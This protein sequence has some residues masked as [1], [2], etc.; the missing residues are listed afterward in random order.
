MDV[1]AANQTAG[2]NALNNAIQSNFAQLNYNLASQECDTRRTVTDGVRD[3]ID[4]GANNTRAILDFLVQDKIDT[5]TAEN[6][7]LKGQ[8][9]QSE[10]NAY[11]VNTLRPAVIPSYTVPNPYAYTSNTCPYSTGC[12][13]TGM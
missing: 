9:S 1:L 4:A 7:S 10:Q 13:C 3:L 2:V 12:G 6:Q 8:I 5:L 11:L